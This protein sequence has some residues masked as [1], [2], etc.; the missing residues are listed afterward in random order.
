MSLGL[1]FQILRGDLFFFLNFLSILRDQ[2]EQTYFL[3][4][5]LC[6]WMGFPFLL[7]WICTPL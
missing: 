5:T 6:Q 2:E 1:M 4:L 3:A 7:L